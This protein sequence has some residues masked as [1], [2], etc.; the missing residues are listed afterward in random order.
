VLKETAG[1]VIPRGTAPTPD[2]AQVAEAARC[3]RR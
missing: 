3:T 1:T 2:R